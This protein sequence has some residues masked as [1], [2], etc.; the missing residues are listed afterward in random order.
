MTKNIFVVLFLVCVLGANVSFAQN[1]NAAFDTVKSLAGEWKGVGPE[2]NPIA[3]RFEVVSGG[4]AVI[5][6][7]TNP[8]MVTTYY[9]DGSNLMM[10][11]YCMASNQPRMKAKG[12]SGNPIAF[13]FV[14]ATNLSSPDAG[15]MRAMV[16]TVKDANHIQESWTWSDKGKT[17]THHFELERVQ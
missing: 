11:H 16:L 12:Q 13:E 10:T 5:E 7:L 15:H 9:P 1:N 3:I 4:T 8:D 14:D 2:G 17:Q 6:T